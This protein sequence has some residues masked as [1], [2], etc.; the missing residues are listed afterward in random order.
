[1]AE[2]PEAARPANRPVVPAVRASDADRERVAVT[3]QA[4][5]AE[6]RL[7][8]PELERRLT[9]TYAAAPTASGLGLAGSPEGTFAL[10]ER[11]GRGRPLWCD[12]AGR[13]RM[14]LVRCG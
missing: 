5:F 12:P 4:A 11:S 2:L 6:A 3:L 9:T 13:E 8:M 7:T 10:G 14:E 1:M